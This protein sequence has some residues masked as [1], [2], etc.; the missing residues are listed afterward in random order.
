CVG[1]MVDVMYEL[2]ALAR[3][4]TVIGFDQRGTGASG[5]LRC[6]ELERDGRLR[7]ASAAEQC[8]RRLGP[9]RAFYTTPDS[10]A[11]MEA[12]RRA[13]GAPRL[14]LFGISYGTKLALAYAREHPDRVERL[15]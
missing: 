2:P 10:V 13:V 7:S 8:A 3:A 12:I 1:D 4:Y 15:I 5:V 11:D 6:P 14:T 9:K